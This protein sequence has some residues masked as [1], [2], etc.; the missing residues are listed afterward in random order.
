[1]IERG[2]VP[3]LVLGCSLGSFAAAVVA[4]CIAAEDALVAIVRQAEAVQA[5]CEEGGMTA[6]LAARSLIDEEFLR[7]D[8]DLAAENFATHFVVSSNR[9][10]LERIEAGLRERGVTFQRLPVRFA[11]HSRWLDPA[12]VSLELHLQSLKP[13]PAKL[14]LLCCASVARLSSLQANYFWTAVRQRMRFREAIA[15]LEDTQSCRYID[16]GP[17]GTLATFLKYILPAGSGSVAQSV[18]TPYGQEARHLAAIVGGAGS[19]TVRT[20][21]GAS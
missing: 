16:L 21:A 18:L 10:G 14:P 3:D 15:V 4:G 12:R 13:G 1:L 19:A 11:F 2:V 6:V 9:P 20:S 17:S 5:H 7:K 8:C